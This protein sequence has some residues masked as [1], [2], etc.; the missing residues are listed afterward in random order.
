MK[1]YVLELIFRSKIQ[2]LLPS[3][4]YK[5]DNKAYC[6]TIGQRVTIPVPAGSLNPL[7]SS[8]RLDLPTDWFP[9]TTTSGMVK[10]CPLVEDMPPNIFLRSSY[11]SKRS[12]SSLSWG[13]SNL[14]LDMGI[15]ERI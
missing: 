12:L 5:N 13:S 2:N 9:I 8:K 3:I 11:T 7:K 6:K 15:L 10:L 4:P 14:L 1:N